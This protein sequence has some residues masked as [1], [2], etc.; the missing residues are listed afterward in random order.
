[1]TGKALG[2]T[3]A[4]ADGTWSFTTAK[5][6]TYLSAT[7]FFGVSLIDTA[8]NVV[9]TTAEAI[10]GTLGNDT[11]KDIGGQDDILSGAQG[12]DTFV[13]GTKFGHDVITDFIAGNGT[14]ELIQFSK[15]TFTGYTDLMAHAQQVGTNV[16]VSDAAG[17][18]L[19]LIGINMADMKAV[20]FSFT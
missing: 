9:K 6:S 7:N 17:D 3:T 5:S 16:L 20:D 12:T 2:T 4:G 15:S 18:T 14:H 1:V 10:V 11:I 13:F 8:G 19:T